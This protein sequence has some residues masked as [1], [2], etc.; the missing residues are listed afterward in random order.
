MSQYPN[1]AGARGR[2]LE[3]ESGADA[4][5]VGQ[6]F[7]TVY[8]WMCVGLALTAC[9]GWYFSQNI[10]LLKITY[11]NKGGFAAVGLGAFAIAWIAQAQAGKMSA[12]VATVLFLVY[13]AIIGA[14]L[15]G[16]FLCLLYTSPSPR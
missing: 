14:L 5:T 1:Y 3:Y 13:A 11:A 12:T 10:D 6:F 15:S 2:E 4:I 7:N 9:V 16:I 8:A